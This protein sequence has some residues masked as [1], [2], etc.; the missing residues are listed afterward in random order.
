M[1]RAAARPR[2]IWGCLLWAWLLLAAGCGQGGDTFVA[3]AVLEAP[4]GVVR[5]VYG[6][7]KPSLLGCSGIYARLGQFPLT[8]LAFHS[9]KAREGRLVLSFVN[10]VP[11]QYVGLSMNY[12]PL[13]EWN[14]PR[15][16]DPER[17]VELTLPVRIEA[18]LNMVTLSYLNTD[19]TPLGYGYEFGS[20]RAMIV[21][22]RVEA[23]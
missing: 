17:R 3:D 20:R 21:D 22:M 11:G 8:S 7:G 15:E 6:L 13:K 12:A 1:P 23:D 5:Q 4:R 16:L 10:M 14:L 18:G 2:R 19:A 9:P